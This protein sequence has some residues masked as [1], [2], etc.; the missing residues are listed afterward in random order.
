[1]IQAVLQREGIATLTV[2]T[3]GKDFAAPRRTRQGIGT[4]IIAIGYRLTL[5]G[6]IFRSRDSKVQIRN[7]QAR[8][9]R[10]C[11][12]AIRAIVNGDQIP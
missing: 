8:R 9:R 6:Q 7:T 2:Q 12:R 11:S 4:C 5:A 10:S 1:M 3:D